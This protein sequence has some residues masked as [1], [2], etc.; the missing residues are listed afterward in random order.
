[1]IRIGKDYIKNWDKDWIRLGLVRMKLGLV[2][3]KV[4]SR[5]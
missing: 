4:S 5:I 1:M 2:R 3:I